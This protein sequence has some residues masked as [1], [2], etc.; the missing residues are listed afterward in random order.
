MANCTT[1]TRVKSLLGDTGTAND[2]LLTSLVSSV[3]KEIEAWLGYPV[4]LAARTEL[5]S[6]GQNDSFLFLHVV[7]VVSVAEVKVASS[8]WDWASLTALV[9]DTD[10]HIGGGG[11]IYW[12]FATRAGFENARVTYTAGLGAADADVIAAAPDLS[13]AADMQVAEDW[14]RRFEPSVLSV[15]GPAGAKTLAAPVRF[16]PRVVELLSRYRRIVV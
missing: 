4:T 9:A 16:M 11:R 15:P 13:L 5:H 6:L 14:R 10:Y 12:N 8:G 2:T 1:I 3:S 7:P